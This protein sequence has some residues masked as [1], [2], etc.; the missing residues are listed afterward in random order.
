M[1]RN[2]EYR[3][4]MGR[5]K[6][7]NTIR[8]GTKAQ[9]DEILAEQ[10]N[11]IKKVGGETESEDTIKNRDRSNMVGEVIDA[12]A[13]RKMEKMRTNAAE[14]MAMT[15][16]TVI[17]INKIKQ[18]AA[19]YDLDSSYNSK[20]RLLEF[21]KQLEENINL[22]R[23]NVT[24]L[25]TECPRNKRDFIKL[26]KRPKLVKIAENQEKRMVPNKAC[27]LLLRNCLARKKVNSVAT[28]TS[29]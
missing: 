28:T 13:H 17:N 3:I 22:M 23:A 11:L 4:K 10:E 26:W 29:L 1:F 2:T 24:V 5:K 21:L 14:L 27:L 12:Y 9:V 16:D 20:A 6:A 18:I 15:E 7:E 19:D 25:V 8:A